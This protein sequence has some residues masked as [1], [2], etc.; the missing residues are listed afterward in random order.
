[1][2]HYDPSEHASYEG[3]ATAA[4]IEGLQTFGYTPSADE[5]DQRPLPETEDMDQA[6]S[7][8]FQIMSDTLQDS[9]LEPDLEDLLWSLAN[10]FH[11][12]AATVQRMLD[13]NESRQ[14]Y[15]QEQQ[16]GSEVRS[17]EL[18]N[19]IAHG[20]AILQKRD[21]F[22]TCR[23]LAG[24]HFEA[25]TGSAWRPKAGSLANRKTMTAAILDSKDYIK[26]KR[27]KETNTLT[28]PG[29]LIALSGGVEYNN[30]A[31]IYEKLDTLLKRFPDM[32]LIHGGADKG[33]DLIAT[34]WASARGVTHM[35]F[36][37]DFARW[38]KTRA[39]FMRNDEILKLEP[40]GVLVFDG[41]GVQ[42][43]MADKA[44]AA[45]IPLND[46]RTQKVAR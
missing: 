43:N 37:P 27:Y 16:D 9:A 23:D 21:L 36:K 6:I 15:S 18:E 17:V 20:M 2:S 10:L 8:M 30:V 7:A 46:Y 24:A 38:G 11:R 28:P 40:R 14:R 42:H 29:T 32:I 22:E 13:D 34:K 1:M 25:I 44:K 39:G 45:K 5:I 31:L 19:L 41:T 26:A 12:K 35:P 3:S 4:V 33:A